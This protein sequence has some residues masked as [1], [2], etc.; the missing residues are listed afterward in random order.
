MYSRK[1]LDFAQTGPALLRGY[2]RTGNTQFYL[3]GM[4][5]GA[6]M[7]FHRDAFN[8]LVF[9]KKVW[10]L[11]VPSRRIW[12]NEAIYERLQRVSG[13]LNASMPDTLQCTQEA[14]DLMFV[15]SMF[16]HGVICKSDCIGVAHEF[17][18]L[19]ERPRQERYLYER[20]QALDLGLNTG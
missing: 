12:S 16:S 11:R 3:G 6:P 4:L 14:G 20:R 19:V 17:G 1:A 10:Y 8:S 2:M 15:P 7:H 5:M 9:G 18:G 13:S